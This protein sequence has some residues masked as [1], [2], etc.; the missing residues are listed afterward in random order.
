MIELTKYIN[1]QLVSIY[2]SKDY[3]DYVKE[4]VKKNLGIK[5]EEEEK[6]QSYEIEEGILDWFEE[7]FYE[8]Y[9]K[10]QDE[11]EDFYNDLGHWLDNQ[12]GV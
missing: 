6:D 5:T 11:A 9:E 3:F 1:D 8:E 12:T 10:L 2:I 4:Q 7:E